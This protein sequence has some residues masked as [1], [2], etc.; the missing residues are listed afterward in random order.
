M[1]ILLGRVTQQAMNYAIRSGVTITAT[2]AFKQCGRLLKEA[3]RSK[4]REE[5]MQLQLRLESKI[6][7]ISPAIDM[8]ELIS[9]R[10]NTSLESA[11]GLTKDLRYEIQRLGTRLSDAANDEEFL[12]RKSGRAKSREATEREMKSIIAS[13]KSLLVRIE[14]AV[15]LISLA[16]TTSGVNLS[17][18]LSGTISPSRLLQASTFLT[19]ADSKYAAEPCARQQVGPT[20]T[21]SM[22]MLFAGHIRPNDEKGIRETTWKEIIHKARV[23]LFRVA[24]DQLYSLP[25]EHSPS[26]GYEAGML[27]GSDMATEFEYQLVIVEDLDDGR[28]HTFEENDPQPGALDDV[29]NA[30]IRDAVPV[31]EVS[32]VFYADTGKILGIGGD[33]DAQNPVLLI[34]R[35]VHAAPPRSMLHKSQMERSYF[36][37]P[38]AG[39]AHYNDDSRSEIDARFE[40]E[41]APGTPSKGM[42]PETATGPTTAWRLPSDLD[43]EWIAFEVYAEEPESDTEEDESSLAERTSSARQSSLDPELT[44][45][46]AKLQLRS[47]TTSTPPMTNGQLVHSQRAKLQASQKPAWPPIKTSLSLLEMLIKLTALQQFKQESHLVIGD[48]MLNFFLEDTAT[49]GAGP[50][51][52]R[53]QRIRHDALRRVGFDPYDESPIKR[54]GEEHI[55]GANARGAASPRHD[56]DPDGFPPASFPY[57]DSYGYDP[58][59]PSPYLPR[60]YEQAP[61]DYPQYSREPMPSSPSPRPLLLHQTPSRPSTPGSATSECHRSAVQA[62]YAGSPRSSPSP[63]APVS[64]VQTPPSTARSRQALLRAQTEPK[65]GSPLVREYLAK[66]NDSGSGSGRPSDGETG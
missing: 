61:P 35:D 60:E 50:D 1:D 62:K 63:Q 22:Y 10:G 16:I 44:G 42:Q 41:S 3:P 17:T 48:E 39:G 27:P 56:F 8:I 18:N 24:L 23:K 51:K 13:I 54:R 29:P 6:R 32:K 59:H 52:V 15:P 55:R 34:K 58:D 49:A 2:Y 38:S 26:N 66:R 14:D 25:G 43:P 33:G 65:A 31:H 28:V 9:A 5:L 64:A 46:L 11:V 36:D 30:G 37:S 20:Y 4:D 12:R 47:S 19:A 45:A 40:R 53:R 7:V 21:L 57:D